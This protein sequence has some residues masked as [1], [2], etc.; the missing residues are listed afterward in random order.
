MNELT[1]INEQEIL[2]KKFMIYGTFEN[3]LFLAKDIANWIDHNK[4]NEMIIKVDEDEKLKAIISHAGQNREMWFLT[5]DGLYEVLMQSR[6]PI[7]KEFKK[8]VKTILKEL[9]KGNIEMTPTLSVKQQLQL[10]ILNGNDIERI[11]S[12]KAY[13]SLVVEEATKPLIET[14]ETNKPLVDFAETIANN[15]DSIEIGVFAKLIKDENIN[16]GRNKLFQWLRDNKYLMKN[17]IPYQVYVERNYFEIIEYSVKTPYGEKL[18]TKT[19][20]TGNGQIK[21]LEKLRKEF[22]NK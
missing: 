21:I 6:K 18:A 17:N 15:V 13:E 14:I 8:Q 2:G 11:S 10:S 16:I 9:R 5:E 3:P 1:I 20:I 12:L 19:L 4:P 7:A 22:V